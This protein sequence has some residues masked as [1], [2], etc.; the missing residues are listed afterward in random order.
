M[1]LYFRSKEAK[2][3]YF[4]VTIVTITIVTKTIVKIKERFMRFLE[5]DDSGQKEFILHQSYKIH[6]H[7]KERK[8]CIKYL[9]Y[10]D[11]F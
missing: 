2:I 1:N 4:S 5:R 6:C 9:I 11:N 8:R 10:N 3:Q 7:I